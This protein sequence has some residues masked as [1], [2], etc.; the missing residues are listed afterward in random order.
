MAREALCHHHSRA[1]LGTVQHPGNRYA[2]FSLT[3]AVAC[4]GHNL[5]IRDQEKPRISNQ[6]LSMQISQHDT[7]D[8]MLGAR[9]CCVQD[10]NTTI[11]MYVFIYFLLTLRLQ[12]VIMLV[13][14][15]DINPEDVTRHPQLLAA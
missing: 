10:A 11:C 9:L 2:G 7:A 1:T 14:S 12:R 3:A 5:H 6:D 13:L 4:C 15:E 8:F